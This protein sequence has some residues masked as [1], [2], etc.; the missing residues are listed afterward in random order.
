VKKL[1]IYIP[2]Y[3]RSDSLLKQLNTISNFKDKAK[4]NVVVNDNCSTDIT[5]YK[6]VEKYCLENNFIYNRNE[7]NIG[8]DANI[9]NGFL[10]SFESE[11]IWILSDDD[12]LKYDAVSTIV[13]ILNANDLDILFLTHSKIEK[14]E[15]HNWAQR[16]FF[17]NNIKTS[18][19]AGL[20]SNVIYKSS[21]IKDSIPV[22]FQNIYTCFCHL[23]VLIHSLQN[24][25]AKIANI[26]SYNFFIPETNLPPASNATYS[27]SYFGFVLLGELF[28][29]K[30]KKD[31]IDRYSTFWTLRYWYIKDKD[32][33][34]KQNCI[35][36][37]NYISRNKSIYNFFKFKLFFWFLLTPLLIFIK[38][39]LNRNTKNKILKFFKI[40]F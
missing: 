5:G 14:L 31:F 4:L 10:N 22:G 18:D 34:A 39:K 26:G 40:G 16:D 24:R 23:S 6:E 28:E 30:I 29:K 35:Y 9:F 37:E 21:F 13:N 8:A 32:E 17:E 15:K 11:Y 19:G 27:K 36:A 38:N 25:D 20:I 2:S 12:L 7:T 3:N 1:T 33:I